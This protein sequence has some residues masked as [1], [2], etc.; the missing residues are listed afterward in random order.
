M[1]CCTGEEVEDEECDS[2]LDRNTT[3]NLLFRL[4]RVLLKMMLIC[5]WRSQYE[6]CE[7]VPLDL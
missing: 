1:D 6:P 3:I 5:Q 4:L 7:V 2:D